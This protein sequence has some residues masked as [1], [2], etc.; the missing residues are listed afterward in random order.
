MK[1]I[2]IK[3]IIWA[4]F[5]VFTASSLWA[6]PNWKVNDP[7][8]YQYSMTVLCELFLE[9]EVSTNPNDLIAAFYGNECRAIASPDESGKVFMTVRSNSAAG[10]R[11]AFKIWDSKNDKEYDLSQTLNFEDGATY[12]DFQTPIPFHTNIKNYRLK[13]FNLISPNGD[14]INDK[15]VIDAGDLSLVTELQLVIF[16]VNGSEVYKHAEKGYDNSWCGENKNGNELP[17]GTYIYQ[18]LDKDNKPLFRGSV[19]IVR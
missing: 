16:S 14:G 10:E 19:T 13:A 6:Q 5:A 17:S 2:E 12:G 9:K 7:A 8:Q 11:I 3:K 15:W 18:F 4:L 1:V